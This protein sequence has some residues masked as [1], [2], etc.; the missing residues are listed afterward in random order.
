[1]YIRVCLLEAGHT[2][3]K[4]GAEGPDHKALIAGQRVWVACIS[5][6]AGDGDNRAERTIQSWTQTEGGG[7]GMFR[8]PPNDKIQARLTGHCS[9]RCSSTAVASLQKALSP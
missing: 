9:T 5:P 2:L 8:P 1:M 3:E 4:A 7:Y 6:N